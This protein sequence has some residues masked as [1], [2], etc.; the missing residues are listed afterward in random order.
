MALIDSAWAVGT[1]SALP[2]RG[3]DRADGSGSLKELHVDTFILPEYLG[4]IKDQYRSNKPNKTIIH[5]Q[6]AHCNYAAQQKIAEIIG[7]INKE[8]GVSTVNLEGGAKG[9]D[10]SIF[11]DIADK[12]IRDKV[13]DYFVKEGLVNGAEYYAVNNPEKVSLWG[14]EDTKLYIDNLNVYRSSLAHKEEVDKHLKALNHILSNLKSKIYSQ[15][16]L[17]FDMK[18]SA[19]K[20]NNMEFKDYL[21]SLIAI[22]KSKAIDIKQLPNIFLLNQTLGEEGGMDFKKA[23]NERDELIDRL[24][25][26]LPKSMIEELV[27][28]TVDFRSEKISQ[29][30]FY[31]YL[32]SKAK[33][34]NIEL[35]DLP[36][37]Q[38]YIVYVSMYDA[39]DKAKVMEELDKLEDKVRDALCRND[40][41]RQL[42]ALSKNLSLLK[43][44]FGITLTKDDYNYYKANEDFFDMRNFTAFINKKAPL[45]GITGKL[46]DNVENLDLYR[47]EMERFFECSLER[48]EAFLKN[49]QAA[50]SAIIV[51][52]GFHTENLAELFK[53]QGISYISIMPNFNNCNGYECPYFRLLA[54]TKTEEDK[55]ISALATTFSTIAIASIFN[56]LGRSIQ[57]KESM[58]EVQIRVSLQIARIKGLDGISIRKGNE[59]SY[60]SLDLKSVDGKN[61][62]FE[63]VPWV[64][65][66]GR[67]LGQPKVEMPSTPA[68]P[69]PSGSSRPA[70]VAQLSLLALA[71]SLHAGLADQ[72]IPTAGLASPRTITTEE[73]QNKNAMVQSA[74]NTIENTYEANA[75]KMTTEQARLIK[76][77]ISMLNMHTPY[78]KPEYTFAHVTDNSIELPDS[79]FENDSALRASLVH[80]ALHLYYR[81]SGI[82]MDESE[83]LNGFETPAD[84]WQFFQPGEEGWVLR[85]TQIVLDA[86]EHPGMTFKYEF[87][88]SN[89]KA[90]QEIFTYDGI[91]V[92]LNDIIKIAR[93][94]TDS[95]MEKVLILEKRQFL[96]KVLPLIAL[97]KLAE[98]G[99]GRPVL[100]SE[101][102]QA[103][104]SLQ[105]IARTYKDSVQP[106]FN[107][108]R[109]LDSTFNVNAKD[110]INEAFDKYHHNP[111]SLTEKDVAIIEWW[112][113][114]ELWRTATRSFEMLSNVEREEA[115]KQTPRSVN[116]QPATMPITPPTTIS[117][118]GLTTQA[119]TGSWNLTE[120]WTRS[121]WLTETG[122]SFLVGTIVWSIL[123]FLGFQD[124]ATN[125]ASALASG[126]FF[127]GMHV[128][129][130]PKALLTW[131]VVALT[132]GISFVSFSVMG[133]AHPASILLILFLAYMHSDIN[134][135]ALFLERESA[136]KIP[137][138]RAESKG[139][140]MRWRLIAD[141][142]GIFHDQ[143]ESWKKANDQKARAINERLDE[144]GKME[145]QIKVLK[146]GIDSRFI[147]IKRDDPAFA[148]VYFETEEIVKNLLAASGFSFNNFNVHLLDTDQEN[149]FVLRY[150]ND[151][152]ITS[153]L[154]KFISENGG[155]KDALAF[156]LAHEIR[157]I[158]QWVNDCAEGKPL[159]T[160]GGIK[161]LAVRQADE[162]DADYAL[163]LMD[164]AGYSVR[165][166]SFV[167][168]KF[169]EKRNKPLV[170]LS[171]PP[172]VERLRKIERNALKYFWVSF[173]NPSKY[174]SNEAKEEMGHKSNQRTFQESINSYEVLND[175]NK[176]NTPDDFIFL[177]SRVREKDA[178]T[179][180]TAFFD[181]FSIKSD[182]QKKAYE[183]MC[184]LLPPT[185]TSNAPVYSDVQIAF[186]REMLKPMSMTDLI[187]F[188]KVEIAKP[189]SH[190]YNYEGF[191]I[192]MLAGLAAKIDDMNKSDVMDQD[193]EKQ[194]L[195]LM[196]HFQRRYMEIDI[197]KEK[198][199][200]GETFRRL[201]GMVRNFLQ[202]LNNQAKA[203]N[204][205][206]ENS[207]AAALYFID[208]LEKHSEDVHDQNKLAGG[209]WETWDDHRNS[210]TAI[211]A[212]AAFMKNAP[213]NNRISIVRWLS[214]DNTG[215]ESRFRSYFFKKICEA[216]TRFLGSFPVDI[217]PGMGSGAIS[218]L[219]TLFSN[220]YF[221][222]Y[223]LL[224][225][226]DYGKKGL[227]ITL[228]KNLKE[229]YKLSGEDT[230]KLYE[231]VMSKLNTLPL[232]EN[233]E[234]LYN[235]MFREITIKEGLVIEDALQRRI[236]RD[237]NIPTDLN[238]SV[239]KALYFYGLGGVLSPSAMRNLF[240]D[241]PQED[242]NKRKSVEIF[243]DVLMTKTN[244]IKGRY[245]EKD[246]NQKQLRWNK[247]IV[248]LALFMS[249]DQNAL[250]KNVSHAVKPPTY[251]NSQ[252]GTIN[253]NESRFGIFTGEFNDVPLDRR[254]DVKD[255]VDRGRGI[256]RVTLT[257]SSDSSERIER[258]LSAFNYI[259]TSN[260]DFETLLLDIEKNLPATT[261]R[262]FAV[263]VLFIEKYLKKECNI[264]I[265]MAR[266]FDLGYVQNLIKNL[267]QRK[268]ERVSL[269]LGRMTSLMVADVEMEKFNDPRNTLPN[270]LRR[271][272]GRSIID[273][274]ARE[275]SSYYPVEDTELGGPL[276]QL[277]IFVGL[278]S[279]SDIMDIISSKETNF[280]HKL[281]VITRYFPRKSN[282]RDR[283]LEI[284]IETTVKTSTSDEMERTL[285]LFNNQNRRDKSAML[286]LEKKR[287]ENTKEF[288]ALDNE[289]KWVLHYFPELS[290]TRDD[291]LLQI[292]DERASTFTDIQ[293][294]KP[295]LL[296]APENIMQ[297]EQTYAAF[298]LSVFEQY[299]TYQT[300][301]D[302]AD[303][304]QWVFGMSDK[305]PFNVM[306]FEE[307]YNVNSNGLRDG[308][309]NN[310]SEHYKNIG[311]S[312]M[313][314]FLEKM[315][316]G[317]NGIFY[318][319]EASE[320]FLSS[321]FDSVMPTQRSG[322]LKV[323]YDAVFARADMNR[324]YSIISALLKNFA[325][326]RAAPEGISEARAIRIF[327][328]S[329]GLIGAK[330]GQF[331]STDE[332][333]P[334]DVRNELRLLK[335]RASPMSK[336][337]V[338][339]VIAKVYGS[340]EQSTIREVY[341]CVGSASIKTVYIAKLKD[342]KEVV[343]KIKRPEVEKRVEEDLGFLRDILSDQNVQNALK[344][345]NI[346]LPKQ[347]SDRV[348]EMIK[349]EMNLKQEI[350]NQHRLGRSVRA[351]KSFRGRVVE[352]ICR[353]FAPNVFKI[354]DQEYSFNVPIT[355]DAK[356]N[357]LIME[358]FIS[359]NKL[360]PH[361]I[362]SM[363]AV[364][365][366]L[367]RQIFV[368]G[369]YHA[370]P[371]TG[372]ILV[373]RNGK[374]FNFID[375]GSASQ[376]S[377]RNRYI[378]GALMRALERGD[379]K[380][381]SSIVKKIAHRDVPGI[382]EKANAIVTTRDNVV[383]KAIAV[384]KFLEDSNIS[385][386]KEL[387]SV[388]RCFGQG[389]LLFK[390][391]LEATAVAP[392]TPIAP[393]PM[394]TTPTSEPLA[395]RGITIA[396]TAVTECKVAA[397]LALQTALN[398]DAV[399]RVV[400][401][402]PKGT[403]DLYKGKL[404]SFKAEICKMFAK[405]GYGVLASSSAGVLGEVKDERQIE[406]FEFDENDKTTASAENAAQAIDRAR[407]DLPQNGLVVL[408]KPEC[409]SDAALGASAKGT[410]AVQDAYSD[411]A[412]NNHYPDI[413]SRWV[414]A[415]LIA[416]GLEC[417]K[418]GNGELR[419][420]IT[421]LRDYIGT[422]SQA[423]PAD[424]DPK[425][426]TDI[427]HFFNRLGLLKIRAIDYKEISDFF[428]SQKEIAAAA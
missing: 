3:A 357:T 60:Y 126:T 351:A 385:I 40:D 95:K 214:R 70:K 62:K 183:I 340:F 256:N 393:L 124:L 188:M 123:T 4:H 92:T 16:L 321:V 136:I 234:K 9:Y 240:F 421:S 338:F 387:I 143:I 251:E 269:I 163:A 390:A 287:N 372:N 422:I 395:S 255:R 409:I 383:K 2:G 244:M 404:N 222:K 66:T 274:H 159:Q 35:N 1:P 53:K 68:L 290:P 48:D 233:L 257:G 139:T 13:A 239:K 28:K 335:D 248:P 271:E 8:Y 346:E 406:I 301:A 204:Q 280:N 309:L 51:T 384:F 326:E 355:Y 202:A 109:Q 230:V 339:D 305:K 100:A 318:D 49:L 166:A 199:F 220:P 135:K 342:G 38:K 195:E 258:L 106:S 19:Y 402:V 34:A 102:A 365:R 94:D 425:T 119:G 411:A 44:I 27:V 67:L 99:I 308:F 75:S 352:H 275:A 20:A 417:E 113:N 116:V 72:N 207:I 213:N 193:K 374:T 153:G 378:L 211:D 320:K 142:L 323:L 131:P 388:F 164:K 83:K 73:C 212:L 200:S 363:A 71:L 231:H 87:D 381:V 184:E 46:D 268:R 286:T 189:L 198:E 314:E 84:F 39:I 252:Q 277:D 317:D 22:A 133:S 30:D 18:Y 78:Y 160:E 295:H 424:L 58:I 146:Q 304:L 118:K 190:D 59:I 360:E 261:Y 191:A 420:V 86:L 196:E 364:G 294:V 332:N 21:G 400:V 354:S 41:E 377:M 260:K 343:L 312:A 394:A 162:H 171:H 114:Y 178:A 327:L 382:V 282:T 26:R 426:I 273:T 306:A 228:L 266:I 237:T 170:F 403:M 151:I 147:T 64:A 205:I 249:F 79:S 80:E 315:L 81:A 221:L 380:N 259:M 216:N 121:A 250:D 14:I 288:L 389:E 311:D 370:D 264:V 148:H 206:N 186:V 74:I 6:D 101:S 69:G 52:G 208:I 347:L 362:N 181:K 219:D 192:V 149:A 224:G 373:T 12:T 371:H 281:D 375:V 348:A 117:P 91:P 103:K 367:M 296:R 386:N 396:E 156:V 47:R 270:K 413:V 134:K 122:A 210:I 218:D 15:E 341:E 229:K 272:S 98:T 155:S 319:K 105:D 179:F 25:K 107:R 11:T 152:Y 410:F 236:A 180:F 238:L 292:I 291:I 310:K 65:A 110:A 89:L 284:L 293:K 132:A 120:N 265:D 368:D 161:G 276:S 376:I 209:V 172:T 300:P 125:I 329:M 242:L 337:V 185:I 328:E 88:T 247:Y 130:A 379:S 361:D 10:L 56:F 5:I 104:K 187:D 29:K 77:I 246:V 137:L 334:E 313:E 279:E 324:K 32:T 223:A 157:H 23:N 408:F 333:I 263:Y 227:V 283:F 349:E 297:K 17:D 307:E 168:S 407:R 232:D 262:N 150:G 174:F 254:Y 169:L 358:E 235:L 398:R 415:R 57:G 330:L 129:R 97:N 428:R 115:V 359:G 412:G 298:G 225:E 45:Y 243:Y 197:Y 253:A 356:N 419:G 90:D 158:D 299:Q 63:E 36:E 302:K 226:G 138:V 33:Q 154:I 203:G 31:S 427:R 345:N 182:A 76:G 42:S 128:F 173:F 7:Y 322:I 331:L 43:N 215:K 108:I 325:K 366:E 217:L 285:S 85:S 61:G 112:T 176:A 165:D 167:F 344:A 194:L 241:I 111:D 37:L 416:Y 127:Y 175:M 418:T 401:G 405:A 177:G 391:A 201:E 392:T 353:H 278:L 54:G 82:K 369:F 50:K 423:I 93:G 96:L 141:K 414:I 303:F 145:D 350:I 336:E 245:K 397:P 289:L 55:K 140:E 399:V 267:N 144:I 24:Q 316:L